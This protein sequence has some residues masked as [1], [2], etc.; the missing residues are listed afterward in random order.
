MNDEST[1]TDERDR[2]GMTPDD[3]QRLRSKTDEEINA[4]A[5]TDPDNPALTAEQ[6][7]LFRR[8][9]LVRRIRHKLRMGRQTFAETYGIPLAT[10]TA[11]ERHEAEPSEVELVYLRLIEREPAAARLPVTEPVT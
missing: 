1:S 9:A 2:L 5:S 10:L 11:W 4:A 6:L 8:P 3:W 7:A